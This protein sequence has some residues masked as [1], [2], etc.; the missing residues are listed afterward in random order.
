MKVIGAILGL[1]GFILMMGAVGAVEVDHS[2][3][4]LELV[5]WFCIS[6]IGLLTTF[7]GI[8]IAGGFNE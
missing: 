7:T 3:Q 1:C 8:L 5:M 2:I 6:L 4:G